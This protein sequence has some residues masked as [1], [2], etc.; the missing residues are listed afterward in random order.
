M[1]WGGA[2]GGLGDGRCLPQTIVAAGA[3]LA[4]VDGGIAIVAFLQ[5]FH[6]MIGSSNLGYLAYFIFTLVATCGGWLYW[7]DGCGFILM[8]CPEILF[9]AAFLLLLSF[10]VDLCHQ[11]N[12]EDEED[13]ES[14]YNEALLEKSETKSSSLHTDGHRR[15]CSFRTMHIGNQQKFVILVIVLTFVFMIA[16]ALLIWIGGAKNTTDSSLVARIY[17]GIFSV[18]ILL[19]GCALACYGLPLFSK[20]S[21]IRSEM[22]ST[23]LWKVASL[24]ALT[25]VCFTLYAVLALATNIPLQVLSYRHS[26]NLDSTSSSV[27]IFLYYF[28]GSSVPSGFILW[29][30]RELPPHLAAHRPEES[31]EVTFI[32][33][34]LIDTRNLQWRTA[35]TSSQSK[36]LK[37]S[38]I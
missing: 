16:Y 28:I 22:A 25:L 1:L 9:L 8:A 12:D 34:S 29:V 36:A 33:E 10:W 24:A 19:P 2:K 35:V 27:L 13:D 21:K 3:V 14:S 11:A 26:A 6:L 4:V 18:T 30:M 37:A 32:R 5:I 15:C 23:E 31:R 38:P 20:M 7:S 17:L